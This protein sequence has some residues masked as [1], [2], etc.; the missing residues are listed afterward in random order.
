MSKFKAGLIGC[1]VI[2]DVYLQTCQRF[3]F[4]EIVACASLDIEQSRAKAVQYGIP[5]ACLPDEIISDPDIDA[6]LN[7]TNP[8]AHVAINLAAL[9]A[10]KHVYAEK[11]FAITLEDG[12]KT[13]ALAREKGVL[14]GSAPDTFLGGRWQTIR[15]LIDDGVIGKPIG[16]TAFMGNHG[17]ERHHPDPTPWYTRGGGPLFDMG[18]YYLTAL[19]SLMGP[20]ASVCGMA[21]KSF[22]QRLI[23]FG[24]RKGQM[25]DVAVDTHVNSLLEFENGVTANLMMSF[26]VWD[27]NLPRL[28]IYGERGTISIS[29]PDP[30]FGPNR[31][32][33]PVH[34]RTRETARWTY[35]PRVQ[36][37]EAWE[38]AE[39][40][41]GFNAESRGLGLLDL[42]YAVREGRP[43]RASGDMAHHVLEVMLGII[44]SSATR[45]FV[46]IDST[47][48]RPLPLP[49]DFP[50]CEAR[51]T[52][53]E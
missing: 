34:F 52:A 49:V 2:S 18:P 12:K 39:N 43:P 51:A 1:G 33:G 44:E 23:E 50:R 37:L 41:H 29:D 7:L 4:I 25:I 28:E 8:A 24:P 35:R 21:K 9:A 19:L 30:V 45:Q 3:D 48:T 16:A 47:C 27:S 32:E 5:K 42:A 11:P 38:L 53:A 13:L 40:T 36:G 17:V 31:F 14:V 20:I 46:D 6:I 26:D 22:A 10:G 15:Q